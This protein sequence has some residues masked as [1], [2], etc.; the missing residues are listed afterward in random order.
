MIGSHWGRSTTMPRK[1]DR[2]I[3][4]LPA[5]GLDALQKSFAIYKANG[6]FYVLELGQ[7][8]AVKSGIADSIEFYK[9]QAADLLMRRHLE[10]ISIPSKPKEDIANFWVD[11]NTTV[12]T[13]I[14]FSPLTTS[15][16]TLNYWVGPTT[17][18]MNGDCSVIT[19]FLLQV[20]CAGDQSTFC[21]VISYLA[22]MLQRPEEK[23][24]VMLVMLGGQGTG[25]GTFF[26]L[27]HQIWGRTTLQVS[28]VNEVVGQFN[29]ALERSYALCM[30]EALFVGDRKALDRL[31]SMI[32]EPHCR[33]EQ[34]YQPSRTI[35]SFHRFFAASNHNHFAHVEPDD[36]R[37]VFLRLSGAK[38]NDYR[39]FEVVSKALVDPVALG[40]FVRQLRDINLTKFNIRKKPN[41][42]EQTLQKLQS[43]ER[44]PRYW[45]EVLMTGNFSGRDEHS[46]NWI[47]APFV[48]TAALS[49]NYLNFD[50]KA[51]WYRPIQQNQLA[52]D[53]KQ[54][55]PSSTPARRKNAISGQ[56]RGFQLPDLNTAQSEF[57]Q[58]IGERIEW[59]VNTPQ[60]LPSNNA[61][62]AILETYCLDDG[63]VPDGESVD[64]E[65]TQAAMKAMHEDYF[66]EDDI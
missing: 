31:K 50:K 15:A 55:C 11:P 4:T 42:K 16:S 34:K 21:Y 57:E 20:I 3:K 30:D 8:A 17:A 1:G 29:A 14:A 32:T 13:A 6:E 48:S 65:N 33:I 39:Y 25:K 22:H 44:F 60:T 26:R 38:K 59:E 23:P 27:I 18:S 56:Q 41:T 54:A 64:Y 61:L 28:D 36:R 47:D 49:E 5:S 9:K 7:V 10:S 24:G 45:F 51:G 66:I 52:A 58:F 62:D 53:L 63:N 46:N 40:D 43:L 2:M 12:F 19:E 37:F 35:D